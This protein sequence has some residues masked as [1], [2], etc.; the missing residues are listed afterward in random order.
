[1][2]FLTSGPTSRIES[3]DPPRTLKLQEARRVRD[4]SVDVISD[5]RSHVPHKDYSLLQS[6]SSSNGRKV[7]DRVR[8]V[9]SDTVHHVPHRVLTLLEP[10]EYKNQGRSR[11]GRRMSFLTSAEV[12]RISTV[13][14]TQHLI[15]KKPLCQCQLDFDMLCLTK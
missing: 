7:R 2:S 5:S 11:T 1:M 15:I 12:S 10:C 8:Y 4:K 13:K 6:E 9:I 14:Q 3:H